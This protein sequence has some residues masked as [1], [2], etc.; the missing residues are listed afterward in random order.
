MSPLCPSIL[1][2]NI[3]LLQISQF[4][5]IEEGFKEEAQIEVDDYIEDNNKDSEIN[6]KEDISHKYISKHIDNKLHIEKQKAFYDTSTPSDSDADGKPIVS[7]HEWSILRPSLQHHK[8]TPYFD[9][10]FYTICYMLPNA[11]DESIIYMHY[12][13]TGM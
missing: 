3:D 2:I 9:P 11:E 5:L 8:V 7:L 1:D 6:L 4:K 13:S 12:I 10:P